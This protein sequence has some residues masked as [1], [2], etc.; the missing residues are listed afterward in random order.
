MRHKGRQTELEHKC[1]AGQASQ[2]KVCVIRTIH[3]LCMKPTA[4]LSCGFQIIGGS[5]QDQYDVVE[6][7]QFFLFC[8][9]DI[10]SLRGM[11]ASKCK[12]RVRNE[13]C[14]RSRCFHAKPLL[15]MALQSDDQSAINS[16]R[17]QHATHSH[18]YSAFPLH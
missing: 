2:C 1:L 18:I 3:V 13:K 10:T 12:V 4:F 11:R 15:Q 8:L 14:M 9:V 17:A 6:F 7:L 5:P 16:W